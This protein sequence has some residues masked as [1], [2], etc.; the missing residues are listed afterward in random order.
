MT[1]EWLLPLTPEEA[2][3]IKSCLTYC[4]CFVYDKEPTAGKNKDLEDYVWS[5]FREQERKKD[6]PEP[7]GRP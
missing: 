4:N 3:Y 7:E 1:R 6:L 5:W 2:R